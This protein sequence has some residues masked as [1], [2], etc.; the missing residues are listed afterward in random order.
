MVAITTDIE[1]E[2]S[3]I[4]TQGDVWDAEKDIVLAMF[5]YALV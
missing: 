3:Y 5:V 2:Q 4:A 1:T